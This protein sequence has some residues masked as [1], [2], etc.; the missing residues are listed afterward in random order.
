MPSEMNLL[1]VGW[2]HIFIEEEALDAWSLNVSTK[3]THSAF[4]QGY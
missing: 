1:V 2:K 3:I 4:I